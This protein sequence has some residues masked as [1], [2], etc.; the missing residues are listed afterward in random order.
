MGSVVTL[1]RWLGPWADATK[2]PN[3]ET[4]DEDVDGMR[5]RI[6]RPRRDHGATYLIAPGLHYAG[7]DDPR[8]DRFCRILAAAGHLVIAPF[9]RDYLAL[10]P[11]ARAIADFRRAFDALPKWSDQK[12]VVFSISFGSLLAF[13]LAADVGVA[14]DKLVIFGGYADFRETLRFCLTGEVASGR[15][16]T[17]DPLNQP[18]VLANLL[19]HFEPPPAEGEA[20]VAGWRRYVERTWGRPEM[21][22][23][24]RFCAI[25]LEIA[26]S[27]PASV[28]ELFLVGIGVEPGATELAEA[29][30]VHF[31]ASAL[32]P[33]PYLPRISG[34]VEL[35]HGTDDDVIPFEQ[36]HALAAKL[37][38]ADVRVHITG[39][40]GHTGSQAPKLTAAAKEMLTM[41]RVLR[42]LAS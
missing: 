22:A 8:M 35:V 37:V 7:A 41:V 1:A 6:Y 9:I 23:R 36:S 3:V 33:S 19:A 20:L 31:D 16:A 32:D 12:P 40:Y 2:S 26:P 17:R 11:N 39:L 28:R 25:A 4:V 27:V 5:V 30:L 13:A 24:E 34:R 38:N 10:T 21:K 18:V 29:A 42:V 14:I 15:S